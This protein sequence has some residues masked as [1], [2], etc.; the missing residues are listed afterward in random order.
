[1]ASIVRAIWGKG[2]HEVERHSLLTLAGKALQQLGLASRLSV[3]GFLSK[4][5]AGTTV[6]G[7]RAK[8]V[9]AE[10]DNRIAIAWDGKTKL[11]ADRLMKAYEYLDGELADAEW[12][13]DGSSIIFPTGA[14]LIDWQK[15]LSV[16]IAPGLITQ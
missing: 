5:P 6:V 9:K 3:H 2:P 11:T 15:E 16:K 10:S 8:V 1:M 14:S 13:L 7:A 4:L 12:E